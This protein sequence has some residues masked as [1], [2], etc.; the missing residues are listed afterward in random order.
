VLGEINK[1]SSSY[2]QIFRKTQM[3]ELLRPLIRKLADGQFHS[4]TEL[5]ETFAISRTAIWKYMQRISALGLEVHSVRG[6]GYR[7]PHPVSLLDQEAI[8]SALSRDQISAIRSLEILDSVDS[9][10]SHAMRMLQE[11]G[12]ALDTGQYAVYLAEQQTSGKGRRGRQWVSPYGRNITMT[13]VRLFDTGTVS[14][15]GVSLVVGLAI[16]RALK[17]FGVRDTGVK[18]PNDVVC[19][20]RKL[21]GILLEI[22]GDI[23]GVCQLLIGVGINIR[24]HPDIMQTVTQPWT[25]LYQLCG[26]EIDRNTLAGAVINHVMRALGEFESHG[27]PAFLDE[28]R[29]HD[30]MHGRQV[31]LTTSGGGRLGR[32][33]GIS[34]TGALILETEEGRQLVNG[35]EISLRKVE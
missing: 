9:T 27:M 6:K 22:S 8:I 18:W 25:D 35:G 20:D 17:M 32:A 4:G 11:G 31:E 5:G 30:V 19:K 12:L 34:E 28:W 10:N 7:L 15:D 13:M 21:A 26:C 14:T 33:M 1:Y 29:Q 23:T 24:C 2:P 3:S 16:I